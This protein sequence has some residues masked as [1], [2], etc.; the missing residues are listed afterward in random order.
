LKNLRDNIQAA[1]KQGVRTLELKSNKIKSMNDFIIGLALMAASAW[2]MASKNITEGR[3]IETEGGIFVRADM[4][5]RMLGGLMFFLAFLMV[6]RA[7]NF[8]KAAETRGLSFTI[9]KESFLTII[10]LIVFIAVLKPVGFGITTFT[11]TFF[12]VCLYMRK[13]NE[14]K[15]LSRREAIKKLVFAA[16]F[17]LILVVLVYMVFVKVLLVVLP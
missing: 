4:Y 5:I 10:A 17:S 13:E 16:M 14:G 12:E 8:K 11:F 6:I 7:I 2:L 1:E 15:G 9:T 3:I